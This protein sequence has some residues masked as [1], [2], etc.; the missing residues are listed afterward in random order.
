MGEQSCRSFHMAEVEK[1]SPKR[2]LTVPVDI[3]Y[4][5][6]VHTA[7][8]EIYK[9]TLEGPSP[10]LMMALGQVLQAKLTIEHTRKWGDSSEENEI[11]GFWYDVEAN[12]HDWLIGGQR[13]AR[14]HA[15]VNETECLGREMLTPE[16]QEGDIH[17]FDVLLLPQRSGHL[18]LPSIRIHPNAPRPQSS[19]GNEVGGAADS[20][21]Q[22][23]CETDYLNQAESVMVVPDLSST[24]VIL[25]R[26]D[27][28]SGPGRAQCIDSQCRA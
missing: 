1:M 26:N 15:K 6:V 28:T 19:D 25:G 14:F 16:T 17:S 11:P 13:S 12:L 18:L 4:M 7:Q 23:S 21:T 22:I 5:T 24:T 2:R 27:L 9:G 8:L 3:P 10:S 20:S